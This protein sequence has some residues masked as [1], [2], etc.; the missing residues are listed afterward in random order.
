MKKILNNKA[1]FQG[2]KNQSFRIP[3]HQLKKIQ[4]ELRSSIAQQSQDSGKNVKNPKGFA[5]L[6]LPDCSFQRQI[7]QTA[8]D[9]A[10]QSMCFEKDLV[11]SD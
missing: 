1:L 10:E 11:D 8:V 9:I 4:Q 3:Q 7:I 2:H 5:S 6:A